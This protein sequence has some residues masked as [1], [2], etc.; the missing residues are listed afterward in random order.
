MI[1]HKLLVLD[2]NIYNHITVGKL[3]ALF[4]SA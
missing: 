3:F 4:W 2:R 1:I